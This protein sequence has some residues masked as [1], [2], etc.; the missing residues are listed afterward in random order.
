MKLQLVDHWWL[1]LRR[2][3]TTW[4]TTLVNAL[5]AT[6]GVHWAMLLGVLP[7]L[8]AY[9]R[10]PVVILVAV[11]VSGPTF[12]ARITCQP[13]LQQKIAEKTDAKA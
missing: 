4:A 8:P 3:A 12:L 7:W 2:S 1:V 13:K 5:I 10:V 6:V 9:L 11:I